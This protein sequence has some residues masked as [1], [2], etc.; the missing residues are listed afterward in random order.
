LI[1]RDSTLSGTYFYDKV[2]LP[3]SVSGQVSAAQEITMG[4]YVGQGDETGSF[5]GHFTSAEVFEGEWANASNHKVL[6]FKFTEMK[7][8]LAAISF[9]HFHQDNCE[10]RERNLKNP[11]PE[12]GFYTDTLCSYS[13]LSLIKVSTGKKAVDDAIATAILDQLCGVQNRD[14]NSVQA[15]MNGISDLEDDEYLSL[16]QTCDVITNDKG[17]L[18]I[19]VG[20]SEFNGGA[21]PVGWVHYLNFDLET[22]KVLTLKDLLVANYADRLNQIATKIF[23]ALPDAEEMLLDDEEGKFKLNDNFAITAGGLIFTFNPYEIAAYAAGMPEVTIPYTE[24]EALIP[25]GGLLS[26]LRRK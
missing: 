7:E 1:K 15:Y 24:M 18:A 9:E 22:G 8:G 3:I 2:G 10:R 26:K 17:V 11:N 23:Y 6:P 14:C 12:E 13:D 20:G 21:H 4:E 16:D 19:N 5:K 25:A